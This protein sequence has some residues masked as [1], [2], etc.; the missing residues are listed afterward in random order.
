M[1]AD[2]HGGDAMNYVRLSIGMLLVVY[3]GCQEDCPKPGETLFVFGQVGKTGYM[4]QAGRVTIKP[5]YFTGSQFSDAISVVL[6]NTDKKCLFIDHCGRVLFDAEG[7]D[8][9]ENFVSGYAVVKKGVRSYIIAT[10]GSIVLEKSPLKFREYFSDGLIPVTKGSGDDKIA[11]FSDLQGNIKFLKYKITRAFGS[12]LAPVCEDKT[13]NYIDVHGNTKIKTEYVAAKSFHEGLAAVLVGAKYVREM[14]D[15]G[16]RLVG[17]KWGFINTNG[18]LV[19]P[20]VYDSVEEYSEGLAAVKS[21]HRWGYIDRQGKLVIR[22]KYEFTGQF[23]HGFSRV[24]EDFK[25]DYYIDRSGEK[26]FEP[27]EEQ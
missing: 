12:G 9:A 15:P 2:R 3:L 14:G 26:A 1:D 13:F 16:E 5:K 8:H 24:S 18:V 11:G 27:V 6:R 19:V 4:T 23:Y 10:N 22:C 20:A 25:N 7:Y 17:G 21:N